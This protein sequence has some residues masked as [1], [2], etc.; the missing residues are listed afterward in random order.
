MS[1]KYSAKHAIL[2]L[3]M[4]T[5][6]FLSGCAQ[7]KGSNSPG[8]T[9]TADTLGNLVK[10][11]SSLDGYLH[12]NIRCP[13][14]IKFQVQSG[15]REARPSDLRR[16]ARTSGVFIAERVD[17][18]AAA[19]HLVSDAQLKGY[20]ESGALGLAASTLDAEKKEI[21]SL[22]AQSVLPQ[23]SDAAVEYG[24]ASDHCVSDEFQTTDST[25]KESATFPADYRVVLPFVMNAQLEKVNEKRSSARLFSQDYLSVIGKGDESMPVSDAAQAKHLSMIRHRE[26]QLTEMTLNNLPQ[27]AKSGQSQDS[28]GT[29]DALP[30]REA[31]ASKDFHECSYHFIVDA[32][33]QLSLIVRC[34]DR[35]PSKKP[36]LVAMTHARVTYRFVSDDELRR[37]VPNPV[38]SAVPSSVPSTVPSA[39]AP[40]AVPSTV[41]SAAAPSAVPSSVPSAEPSAAPST[42]PSAVPSDLPSTVPSAV[43]S[44]LPSDAPSG[45]PSSTPS[46]VAPSSVPS[47]VPSASPSGVPGDSGT[48]PSALESVKRIFGISFTK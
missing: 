15:E 32:K 10:K 47:A 7:D 45:T 25:V 39:A 33:D 23:A 24:L 28:P 19:V 41:P 13:N 36:R 4:I 22:P 9:T 30:A 27:V 18:S 48:D 16:L 1:K 37:I 35:V 3:S 29:A 6:Q 8:S 31:Q 12:R 14:P 2:S 42:L 20:S 26:A 5:A 11:I 34:G 17:Y 43:P 44:A 21:G 46:G 38:V 40:S